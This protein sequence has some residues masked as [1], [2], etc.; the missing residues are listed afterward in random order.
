MNA[1]VA[2]QHDEQAADLVQAITLLERAGIIDF[3]G[4]MSCRRPN[5]RVL[6]NSGNSN[7]CRVTSSQLVTV[8]MDGRND[9]GAARPPAELSLHLAIYAARPDVQ[10]V[11]HG[12]PRWST[13]LSSAGV[14][15][16]VTMSQGALLAPVARFESP[17]SVNNRKLAG[18]VADALGNNNALLLRSHGSVVAG[19]NIIETA[20]LAIYLELNAERQFRVMQVGKPY[21]FSSDEIEACRKGLSKPAL[22]RKCW[23]YYLTRHG[24]GPDTDE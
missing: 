17:L 14:D 20:V 8:D 4:H 16:A 7:R 24:L 15:Y 12:H 11:L 6:I 3:N 13:L 23:D 18:Q 2:P 22:I 1:S 10:V 9:S 19:S 5:G 21:L